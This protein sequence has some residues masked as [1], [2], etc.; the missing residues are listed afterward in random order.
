MMLNAGTAAALRTPP[1]TPAHLVPLGRLLPHL[2]G[3]D[4]AAHHRGACVR[5]WQGEERRGCKQLGA[6]ARKAAQHEPASTGS[7]SHPSL[8]VNSPMAT[9]ATIPYSGERTSSTERLLTVKTAAAIWMSG[10]GERTGRQETA[11]IAPA[12]PQSS[13]LTVG[14]GRVHCDGIDGEK[15]ARHVCDALHHAPNGQV[16]AA[17]GQGGRAAEHGRSTGS[18]GSSAGRFGADQMSENKPLYLPPH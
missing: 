2:Q 13:P 6:P 12:G 14:K 4:D 10:G 16:E 9:Y 18:A 15:L 17:R 1:T 7:K 8:A 11:R 5:G 3:P